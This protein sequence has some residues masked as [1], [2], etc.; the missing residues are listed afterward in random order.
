M[1]D[2]KRDVIVL[3]LAAIWHESQIFYRI[4]VGYSLILKQIKILMGQFMMK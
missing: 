1:A 2:F 4:Y 3:Y